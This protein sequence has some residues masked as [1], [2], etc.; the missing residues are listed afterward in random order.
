[1]HVSAAAFRL[2]SRVANSLGI[3]YDM[4]VLVCFYLVLYHLSFLCLFSPQ[5]MYGP[6][7]VSWSFYSRL[8]ESPLVVNCPGV[9]HCLV[10]LGICLARS[11]AWPAC[12]FVWANY[13]PHTSAPHHAI[14]H[15]SRLIPKYQ[16]MS[17]IL[18]LCVMLYP[19]HVSHVAH[20]CHSSPCFFRSSVYKYS[21]SLVDLYS[22]WKRLC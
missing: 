12:S 16:T 8:S 18:F 9:V 20:P 15:W 1:M 6:T 5:E 3:Q 17:L 22:H 2:R 21:S 11:V 7:T 4:C 13:G 19:N 14:H 10:L